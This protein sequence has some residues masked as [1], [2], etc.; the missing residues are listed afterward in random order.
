MSEAIFVHSRLDDLGLSASE[1]RI[2]ARVARRG[3][4][5]ESIPNM[6]KGCFLH[7]KTVEAALKAL[8]ARRVI[9]KESRP[10]ASSIYKVAP[11]SEWL[12]SEPTPNGYP[13]QTDTGVSERGD[14]HPKPIPTHP[15]QKDT[16]EGNPLKVI[17]EGGKGREA[18]APAAEELFRCST[19]P[20]RDEVFECGANLGLPQLAVQA[21]W[22]A[23]DVPDGWLNL[24]GQ[25]IAWE[26]MMRSE[27]YMS[28]HESNR[29]LEGITR[30]RWQRR[31][32]K[33]LARWRKMEIPGGGPRRS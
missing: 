25:V 17:P 10:G 21:L 7:R 33:K 5:T 15:P 20:T 16:D 14:T 32:E 27:Y 26:G 24:Q 29:Q 6:A 13:P 12:D 11:M 18:N 9:L 30:E 28:L 4:C 2:V 22:D 8:T 1:F 3:E 23:C 19:P 31:W